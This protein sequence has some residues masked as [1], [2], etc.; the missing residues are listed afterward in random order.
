MHCLSMQNEEAQIAQRTVRD[1]D[2]HHPGS[3]PSGRANSLGRHEH[4]GRDLNQGIADVEDGY[5]DVEL[6][7]DKTQVTLKR[8]ETGVGDGILIQ[9][10]CQLNHDKRLTCS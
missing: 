1:R 6:I 7:T 10:F 5:A 8:I 9:S 4:V 2:S 3:H